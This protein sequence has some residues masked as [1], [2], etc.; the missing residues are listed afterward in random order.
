MRDGSMISARVYS[1]TEI[2]TGCNL[3]LF[4]FFHGGGFCIG[5]RYDDYESNRTIARRNKVVIISPEYRLAP[6]YPFPTAV[7]DGLDTLQWVST[8]L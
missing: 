5:S 8:S 6:E 7:H 1:P 4:I 3:P 2:A